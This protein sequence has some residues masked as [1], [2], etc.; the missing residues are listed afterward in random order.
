MY[1][2]EISLE[3]KSNVDK[4]TLVDDFNLLM[5]FYRSNGQTQGKIESQFLQNN[6][7]SS[8]PFSLEK[9][10]LKAKNNNK[11]VNNQ[12]EK[13]QLLAKSTISIETKGK[14]YKNYTGACRCKKPEFYI[15]ITNYI[16][17]ESPLTCGTCN[18]SVPLYTLPKYKDDGYMPILGWETNYQ[19]CDSLQ[20]NCE[21]GERWALNQMQEL[22]SQLS[23]QGVVI[24]KQ[25][26]EQTA[27]PTFYYLFN[28][29]KYKGDE[30]NRPCPNCGKKWNLKTQLHGLYDFKCEN[31][32]IVSNLS[33][34][35]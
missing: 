1:V 13:I 16:T 2:H 8:L 23:K 26:E 24:C 10:S 27:V 4:D 34:Y 3:I 35:S 22:S 31:C 32:K 29:K 9:D 33:S 17:I 5:A 6:R 15:L 25:I 28:Y 11:Y 14:T 20:M 30:Q 21:V 7:I 12:I 19:S 18:N